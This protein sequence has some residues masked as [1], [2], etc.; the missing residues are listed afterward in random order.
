MLVGIDASRATS[1]QRTGTE[2][3]SLYLIRHL[4]ALNA[5]R[6]RL[7]FN[8]A[9]PPRLF[10]QSDNWE[11]RVMPFPRLWTHL[12]LSWEMAC[13]PPDLLFVPAHVIPL[14]HPRSVVTVHDLGYIYYPQ[15]HRPFDRLYLDLSTRFNASVASQIIADSEAT[16]NDLVREYG[17]PEERI[18]VVYPGCNLEPVIDETGWER[19]RERYHLP[20]RYI[21]HLGTLHP[22][23]NILRLLEAFQSLAGDFPDLHLV[24]AGKKGW[25]YEEILHKA[26]GLGGRVHFPGY[27]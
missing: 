22:R 16:K 9:P 20:D 10:P 8:A 19:V 3:Y 4:L 21:L 2:N 15:A 1:P 24:L 6:Y 12:R 13:R 14:I 26:E 7:Y 17:V 25:L 5:Q 18:T 27:I 23:K 11:A